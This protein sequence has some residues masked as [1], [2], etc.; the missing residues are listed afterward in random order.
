MIEQGIP[1]LA[2]APELLVTSDEEQPVGDCDGSDDFLT[3]GVRGEQ[4]KL[5]CGLENEGISALIHGIK[6]IATAHERR[7]VLR[8]WAGAFQSFLKHKATRFEIT[9]FGDS[10]ICEDVVIALINNAAA[11]ALG[12][13][14]QEPNT[15]RRSDIAYAT[16]FDRERRAAIAAHGDDVAIGIEQGVIDERREAIAGP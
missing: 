4:F 2:D 15:V 6:F 11:N 16:R 7:P 3:N 10:A 5:R 8:G 12:D 13:F 9:T 1:L 14:R